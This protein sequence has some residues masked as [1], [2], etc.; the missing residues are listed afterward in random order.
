MFIQKSPQTDIWITHDRYGFAMHF[1][2][3]IFDG[4]TEIFP[5]SHGFDLQE[6]DFRKISQKDCVDVKEIKKYNYIERFALIIISTGDKE[7]F[8]KVDLKRNVDEESIPAPKHL[9]ERF[10]SRLRLPDPDPPDE[11]PLSGL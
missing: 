6:P 3:P 1:D 5:R 7:K 4:E 8:S 10:I 11:D 9:S 2:L